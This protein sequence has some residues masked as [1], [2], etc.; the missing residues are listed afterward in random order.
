VQS[1][2]TLHRS[3][4]GRAREHELTD[5]QTAD[6]LQVVEAV[7]QT[8]RARLRTQQAARALPAQRRRAG[9]FRQEFVAER[10]QIVDPAR[11]RDTRVV[12]EGG[13]Y[14]A[15]GELRGDERDVG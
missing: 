10:A 2:R 9:H 14:A 3:R 13:V 6:R 12:G 4:S 5:R 15:L 8:Q 11:E 7:T 1:Q